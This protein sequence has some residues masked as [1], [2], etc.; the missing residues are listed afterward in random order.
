M[1][2]GNGRSSAAS[3]SATRRAL[4]IGGGISGIQAALDIADGGYEVI[5]VEKS[6]SIGG[7]MIQLSEVFPTLDCPQCIMTPKMVEIS[8]H[9][10]VRLLTYSE[11]VDVSGAA[12]NFKVRIKRKARHVDEEMCTGCDECAKME[13]PQELQGLSKVEE[14]FWVDRIRIDER[15]CIQCGDCVEACLEENEETQGI[16]S[17][18][19]ERKKL[20][21]ALP[22]ERSR[23]EILMHEVARMD[24][25][26]RGDFWHAELSK[27]IKC[28]GCRDVCPLCLC[29]QCEM[30]DPQWVAPGAVPPDHPLFHLIWAYHLADVCVGCGACEATCPMNIPLMTMMHLARIDGAKIFDYVPGLDQQWKK[31]LIDN[32][33]EQPI[34]QRVTKI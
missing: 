31:E 8:Q 3:A 30:D 23:Q 29:A 19:F 28:Y 5:L 27:C 11:V 32:L 1:S 10:N 21:E 25:S 2:A 33:R 4:V 24:A 13:L 9:P 22:Q 26:A 16:T 12:G 20:L 17:I 34:G 7:H 18:A 14:E 6:P 15:E